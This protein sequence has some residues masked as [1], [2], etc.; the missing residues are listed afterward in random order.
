MKTRIRLENKLTWLLTYLEYKNMCYGN[1]KTN[2]YTQDI[3]TNFNYL[4]Y[5]MW[6]VLYKSFR[7]SSEYLSFLRMFEFRKNTSKTFLNILLQ[8]CSSLLPFSEIC[9]L[10]LI[11]RLIFLLKKRDYL[12]NQVSLNN[13]NLVKNGVRIISQSAG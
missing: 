7:C 12:P 6:E 1:A 2:I 11:C 3:K 9:Q 13:F 10:R 5:F 4:C 8:F